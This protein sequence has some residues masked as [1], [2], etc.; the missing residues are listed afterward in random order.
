MKFDISFNRSTTIHWNKENGLW[1]SERDLKYPINGWSSYYIVLSRINI[2][3]NK[4]NTLM[5]FETSFNR[6]TKNHWNN[7][8]GLWWSGRELKYPIDSTPHS[9]SVFPWSLNMI[10]RESFSLILDLWNLNI[11]LSW[12]LNINL[13]NNNWHEK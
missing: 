11:Y 5:K 6:S 4:H 3:S 8:N 2:Y 1:W 12:K 7:E 10:T 13:E 9:N